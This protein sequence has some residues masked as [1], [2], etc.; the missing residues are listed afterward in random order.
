MISD[1]GTSILN[2]NIL[3]ISSPH[4]CAT[5]C[6]T[7]RMPPGDLAVK[8]YFC[9]LLVLSLCLI[10]AA[11]CAAPAEQTH[12]HDWDDGVTAQAPTCA[13]EGLWLRT[14]RTCGQSVTVPLPATG[15][16][17]GDWNCDSAAHWRVCL[18]CKAVGDAQ[19]HTF[20]GGIC[21]V[22]GASA[23]GSP[24]HT[25]EWQVSERTEATCTADGSVLFVCTLCG[26]SDSERIPAL[27]HDTGG[28]W[29]SD[30]TR[31][32]KL[33]GRCGEE[34]DAGT[35][36]F[37][38]GNICLTCGAERNGT[39]GDIGHVHDWDSGIVTYAPTCTQTG[40]RVRICRSCGL[41]LTEEI[42]SLGHDF[43]A[44]YLTDDGAH[45]LLCANGCGTTYGRAL[46]VW[47]EQ[48]VSEPTCSATGLLQCTC[49]I[50]GKE[51]TE[52]LPAS[53]HTQG[54]WEHD[55]FVHWA[56]CSVCGT[57]VTSGTHTW[58]QTEQGRSCSVCGAE[59]TAD[60]HSWQQV[61]YIAPTC[62]SA[63]M[64]TYRCTLCGTTR[65]QVLPAKAHSAGA[66]EHDDDRHWTS[67]S[68]CGN[69][70]TSGAHVWADEK[71][72]VCN[73]CGFTAD[74]GT[75]GL[76]YDLT[77]SADGGGY[78]VIG[79]AGNVPDTVII[80]DLHEGRPV[81]AVESGAF[82]N[83]TA[84]TRLVLG[85]NVRSLSATALAGCSGLVSITFGASFD[86]SSV[87][88][89][90]YRDCEVL[91]EIAVSKD[92]PLLYSENNC[93]ISADG[94]LLLGGETA[95]IPD[96][97]TTIA[98]YAFYRRL[99]LE[100][101][102]LP[103]SVSLIGNYAFYEC[104]GLT[105]VT[106]NCVATLAEGAFAE[107]S[108]LRDAALGDALADVGANAFLNCTALGTI[109]L[110]AVVTIGES[111]FS[112]CTNLGTIVLGGTLQR[113]S[114]NA[115]WSCDMLETVYFC[116]TEDDWVTLESASSNASLTATQILFYRE[117]Q[118]E[119]GGSF[120]HYADGV[121]Q[122]W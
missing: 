43:S 26:G 25:H 29:L 100:H 120:W 24:S 10:G 57:S 30:E 121:P 66:W 105:G 80:P 61:E 77:A 53:A 41:T 59:E 81:I 72:S 108:A 109:Q 19:A 95:R 71:E 114:D 85:D 18:T 37:Q 67:C 5:R 116:G 11:A 23:S 74:D 103:D 36:L 60:A 7:R 75:K 88:P 54:G 38:G 99:T 117:T 32:W 82:A 6:R 27:G 112:G 17:F 49:G 107:C 50:C 118:P 4:P 102:T 84:L 111:A 45:W 83:R 51:R 92:N 2:L 44:G 47:T 122:P 70:V 46:H 39:G 96:G 65:S 98:P 55:A 86:P 119:T 33:C 101:I 89:A 52:I 14:C 56:S 115:F 69:V 20:E 28:A 1:P 76:L 15:H 31:H 73:I 78:A 104:R 3:K 63:G 12:V 40:V 106:A 62:T 79:F 8:K 94:A 113:I 13:A 48:I 21:A 22:C 35:H 42:A 93:L 58:I 110:P 16:A 90:D 64:A 87:R 68:V 97:V 91:A 34:A 9:S